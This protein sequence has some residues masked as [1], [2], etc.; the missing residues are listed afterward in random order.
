MTADPHTSLGGAN[1]TDPASPLVRLLLLLLLLLLV[2]LLLLLLLLL[3]FHSLAPVQLLFHVL[4]DL[5]ERDV[6]RALV[7]HLNILLPCPAG[8]LSLS[9]ELSKLSSIVGIC[10]KNGRKGCMAA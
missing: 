3:C 5:V 1:T 4:R 6:T 8:Q 10:R 9:L 7:H 2:L